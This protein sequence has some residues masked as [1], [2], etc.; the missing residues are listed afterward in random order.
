MS[1][2]SNN[3]KEISRNELW[4][5]GRLAGIDIKAALHALEANVMEFGKVRKLRF[6]NMSAA[7]VW[8]ER[9]DDLKC[10]GKFF[11]EFV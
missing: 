10:D 7:I 11:I 2:V 6:G 8:F 1:I 4:T 9:S 5:L 3:A